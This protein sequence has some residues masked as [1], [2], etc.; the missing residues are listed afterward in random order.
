MN[1]RGLI[2]IESPK[3]KGRGY[4]NRYL[5]LDKPKRYAPQAPLENERYAE[6]MHEQPERY[7]PGGQEHYQRTLEQEDIDLE[8]NKKALDEVRKSLVG[9]LSL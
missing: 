1:A 3:K 4:H 9:K 8:R 5:I 6:G 2:S 7:A